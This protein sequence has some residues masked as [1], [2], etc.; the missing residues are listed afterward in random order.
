[1]EVER[2][3][4]GV[5]YGKGAL[6]ALGLAIGGIWY[7]TMK[8]SFDA[9]GVM[10]FCTVPDPLI[11]PTTDGCRRSLR[12]VVQIFAGLISSSSSPSALEEKLQISVPT[13]SVDK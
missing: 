7:K 3:E 5:A 4:G 8:F 10:A 13:T 9:T 1:M 2:F 6:K 11:T 12:K